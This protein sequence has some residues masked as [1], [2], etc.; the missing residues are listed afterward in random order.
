MMAW[1]TDYDHE[2]I[3]HAVEYVN[4]NVHTNT[5]ESFWS[6]LSGACTEPISASNRFICFATSRASFSLQHS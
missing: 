2:V 1:P 6:L 5:I 3:N 4:G